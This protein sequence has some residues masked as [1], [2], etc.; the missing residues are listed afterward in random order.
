MTPSSVSLRAGIPMPITVYAL[1]YDGFDGPIE[2]SAGNSPGFRLDGGT[3]PA[4]V[5]RIRM[6]LTAMADAPAG[7]VA[8]DLRGQ[9]EIGGKTV[10]GPVIAAEDM[11]QAFLYRHLV[12][13]REMMILVDKP[14][15]SPLIEPASEYPIRVPAG[16]QAQVIFK[17]ARRVSGQNLR[18][19]LSEPPA[20]IVVDNVSATTAQVIGTIKADAGVSKIGF[21]DNLIVELFTERAQQKDGKPT[22]K[23][24]RVSVGVLPAIRVKVVDAAEVVAEI[25]AKDPAIEPGKKPAV[26]PT[27]KPETKPAKKPATKP[28][29]KPATKPEKIATK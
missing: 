4:G 14:R 19:E 17:N 24:E 22:G 16:G 9:A 18:M 15:W 2:V 23:M 10:R 7:L 27:T 12:P 26:E 8:L 1:R 21:E 3:I 28:A 29:K 11:M 20:G 13:S 6:T 5:D 25:P